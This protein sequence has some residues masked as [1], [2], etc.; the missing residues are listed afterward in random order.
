M[1]KE[2]R[3][4]NLAGERGVS[5]TLGDLPK[6]QVHCPCSGSCLIKKIMPT[7][8]PLPYNWKIAITPFLLRSQS[9]GQTSP[10]EEERGR[11]GVE[12]GRTKKNEFWRTVRLVGS[13][14]RFQKLRGEK[15]WLKKERTF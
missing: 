6:D 11:G 4:P 15:K 12:G 1:M 14:D 9:K 2:S 8:V 7:G 5:E 10:T 3:D 13:G